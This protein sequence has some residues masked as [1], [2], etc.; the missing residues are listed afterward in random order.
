MKVQFDE[1]KGT[2]VL[3]FPLTHIEMAKL[4]IED[5]ANRYRNAGFDVSDVVEIL[6]TISETDYHIQ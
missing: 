6:L 5:A 4:V 3:T 1:G 2:V